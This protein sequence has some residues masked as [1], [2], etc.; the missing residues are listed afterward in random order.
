MVFIIVEE[1]VFEG[2]G[3]YRVMLTSC[4]LCR[5]LLL[6]GHLNA[7]NIVPVIFCVSI[8][9]PDLGLTIEAC[10]STFKILIEHVW[11]FGVVVG[12]VLDALLRF[13]LTKECLRFAPTA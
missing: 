4:L 10:I 8:Q 12:F 11:Q 5:L 3:R 9:L 6:A 7:H 13:S 1:G 2:V